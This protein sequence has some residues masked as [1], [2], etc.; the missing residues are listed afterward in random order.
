MNPAAVKGSQVSVVDVN[1]YSASCCLLVGL[2]PLQQCNVLDAS[3]KWQKLSVSWRAMCALLHCNLRKSSIVCAVCSLYARKAAPHCAGW[4]AVAAALVSQAM[5]WSSFS[6]F[7]QIT[8]IANRYR[9]DLTSFHFFLQG[10]A[11]EI[12]HFD[13]VLCMYNTNPH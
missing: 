9:R 6:T 10:L 3:F 13:V 5:H 11:V 4:V 7:E 12:I 2:F 1:E 8:I